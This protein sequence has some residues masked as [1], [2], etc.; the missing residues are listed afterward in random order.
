MAGVRW[1]AGWIR[2]SLLCAC[3]SACSAS[4]AAQTSPPVLAVRPDQL[5]IDGQLEDWRGARFARVGDRADGRAELALGYD[6]AGLYVAARVFDDAFVRSAR[7]SQAEDA[8]V[9]RLGL[10]VA[11]SWQTSELWLF[12]G[13]PGETRASAQLMAAGAKRLAELGGGVSIVE[14]PAAQGYALEAFVP[15]TALGSAVARDSSWS[16]A[17]GLARLHDVDRVGQPGH[18]VPA[19]PPPSA[20]QLP[21]LSIDGG[22]IAALS[23]FLQQ[24]DL[25]GEAAKLDWVGDVR[26][27]A[28]PERVLV[29]GTYVVVSGVAADFSFAELPLTRA[30]DVRAAEMLDLTGDGK[31]ELVLRL[32]TQSEQLERDVW[33]VFELSAATPHALFALET[34]LTTR[35]G[36]IDAPV[37]VAR[38]APGRPAPIRIRVGQVRGL[39]AD[40]YTE[41]PVPNQVAIPVPW[42]PWLERIYAWDGR[43]FTVQHERAGSV[44][45]PTQTTS[46]PPVSAPVEAPAATPSASPKALIAAY[47]AARG[48]PPDAAPRFEQHADVAGDARLE[49]LALFGTECLVVGEGFREGR[50]FYYFGLPVREA[51]QVLRLFSGDVT[52]DGRHELLVR[53]RQAVGDVTREILYV[54]TFAG[55][56]LEPLLA[57]EVRRSQGT[58]SV[59]NQVA[60]VARASGSALQ[61]TP[62][63]AHGWSAT[64]YPFSS[65]S[66]D[67]VAPLLLPWKDRPLRY[68]YDGQQLVPRVTNEH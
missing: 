1:R 38:A 57:V 7:P 27:D 54:Y 18:D 64:E 67:G 24:R 66:R 34:H 11:G 25:A 68:E 30:V 22:P 29:I 48:V 26:D 20:A 14:A 15:W 16:F 63:V 51:A 52:G 36:S 31:P 37:T 42:G 50:A 17:R 65:E 5:R 4:A 10:P 43:Q 8:L 41:L 56:Q 61:I 13:K 9:L 2:S 3:W 21:W 32:H 28:R 58:Q 55:E 59:D 49:T 6:S 39:S 60:L 47:R 45:A 44:V 19:S 62:G 23:G 12:A 46:A 35:A 53:I 33:Q 40:N